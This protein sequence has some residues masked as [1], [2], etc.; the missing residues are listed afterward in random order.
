MQLPAATP[1]LPPC[2]SRSGA[3]QVFLW[4]SPVAHEGYQWILLGGA[5]G[6]LNGCNYGYTAIPCYTHFRI[7]SGTAPPYI[8]VA[9]CH[10]LVGTRLPQVAACMGSTVFDP[11]SV[12]RFF[13]NGTGRCHQDI[14]GGDIPYPSGKLLHNY[15]TSP[16]Y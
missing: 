7:P 11:G 6:I 1:H 15:G 9:A 13:Q 4:R 8:L 12:H 16:C 2:G 14:F 5:V 10:F 3:S